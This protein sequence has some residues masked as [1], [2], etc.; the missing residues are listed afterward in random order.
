MPSLGATACANRASRAPGQ[1]GLLA[2]TSRLRRLSVSSPVQ[3]EAWPGACALHRSNLGVRLAG[4]GA[5]AG[6][7]QGRWNLEGKPGG[8]C[9][10]ETKAWSGKRCL[11]R[12]SL[13]QAEPDLDNSEPHDSKTCGVSGVRIHF[14][15]PIQLVKHRSQECEQTTSARR[16]SSPSEPFRQDDG[17]FAIGISSSGCS[18]RVC[19]PCPYRGSSSVTPASSG[20]PP[21]RLAGKCGQAPALAVPVSGKTR[22]RAS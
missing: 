2:C 1:V 20:F 22:Q 3:T 13:S 5:A 17:K 4:A 11:L 16:K 18:R 15:S 19:G 9:G 14:A 6:W 21:G 12:F 8:A 7:M 10:A